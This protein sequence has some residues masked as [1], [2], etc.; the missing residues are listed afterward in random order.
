MGFCLQS[1][2]TLL[3]LSLIYRNSVIYQEWDEK[4]IFIDTDLEL[5]RAFNLNNALS[6]LTILHHCV[7]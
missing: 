4:A 2:D 3:S 5:N 1:I 7:V 6:Y